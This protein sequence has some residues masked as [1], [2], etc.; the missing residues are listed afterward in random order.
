MSEVKGVVEDMPQN[1]LV[2]A[3]EG[4]RLRPTK[5][6]GGGWHPTDSFYLFI[7]PHC[8]ACGILIP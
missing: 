5:K 2:G 1:Q 8:A 3:K 7:W 4:S 6:L